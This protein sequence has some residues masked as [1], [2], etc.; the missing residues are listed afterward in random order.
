MDALASAQFEQVGSTAIYETRV[1]G[2]VGWAGYLLGAGAS[3]PPFINYDDSLKKYG[4]SYLFATQRPA[5]LDRDPGGFAKRVR[6]YIGAATGNRAVVWLA[7]A[8]PVVFGD[9]KRYGVGFIHLPPVYQVSGNLNLWFAGN[10]KFYVLDQSRIDIDGGALRLSGSATSSPPFIGFS[11]KGDNPLGIRIAPANSRIYAYVPFSGANTGCVTFDGLLDSKQAFVAQGLGQGFRYTVNNSAV[12]S[13]QA[14]QYAVMTVAALPPQLSIAGAFDLGDPANRVIDRTLLEQGY[15]RSGFAIK[16][17]PSLTS[18]FRTTGGRVVQLTPLGAGSADTAPSLGAGGFA[19]ATSVAKT[20]ATDAGTA[21]LSLAGQYALSA[22]GSSAGQVAKLMGGLFGSE[23]LSFRTF[24]A[25][26]PA[27][28]ND[29]LN[30][31]PSK[32]GYAPVFPFETADLNRPASGAVAPRLTDDY[33]TS[34]V[35]II[36]GGGAVDYLAEPEGSAIYGA[37]AAGAPDDAAILQSAPP[38][39]PLAQGNDK[40]FPLVPYGAVA[41][42]GLDGATLVQFE[43]QIVAATRKSLI[44]SYG[45]K[46]WSA[47]V[48]AARAHALHGVLADGPGTDGT[49]PQGFIIERDPGTGAYLNVSMAQ[50]LNQDGKTLPFA[51]SHPTPAMQDALQTNQ[52]FLVA[53]NPEPFGTGAQFA[54]TVN[55]AGWTMT[56]AVGAGASATAYR[57]VMIMKFCSGSLLDRVTNA[58]RWTSAE[59]FSLLPGTPPATAALSYT[60]LSQWLQDYIADAIT[61]SKGT[62]GPFYE[63]FARIAQDPNWTGV[64]VLAADL[65]Q[66]D[67]PPEIA[68]LAAGIDFTRFNAHHFGFTVSRVTVEASTGRITMPP[69]SSSLFGLIDY[70]DPRYAMNVSNGVAP[71]VPVPVQMSGDFDFTVLQLQSLFENARLTRFESH[72]QLSV[73]ALFG[74]PVSR[75]YSRGKPQPFTGIVLKGSYVDQGG[76]TAYVFEQNTT[77]VLTSPSNVLLAVAFDRVQFNT[78]GTQDQGATVASNFLVWGQLDFTALESNTGETLDLLSFGSPPDTPEAA[79]G[80]GLAFSGLAVGM[81]YPQATPGAKRFEVATGNLAWNLNGSTM[82]DT[83][84]FRGFALQLK[85]FVNASGDQKPSDLGFLPVTSQLNLTE[86]EG[87]WFGVV[88]DITLGGPGALASGV[89]F[90]SQL[91]VAWSP[92]T[93]GSDAEHAVFIGMSLPGAA[94]GASLFSIQGV[95]KVAVGAISILRQPVPTATGRMLADAAPKWFYCLRIDDIAIKIFGIAKLPPSANIQ[96]FLFGDPDNTGSLGWYAAYVAD[97][98]PGCEQSL[99]FAKRKPELQEPSS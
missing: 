18:E 53:V 80:V 42:S 92:V 91:L 6:D 96:F 52:L 57:N 63:N 47:R 81:T 86:L 60:G 3:L 20:V 59:Q 26:L 72:V 33:Q 29:R 46:T 35:T 13:L 58:N 4:G 2:S 12:S 74:A 62:S 93:T 98:N 69:G 84:L 22:D 94:P 39:M 14:A 82:R 8:N 61:R 31:I 49:T 88:Y 89:G 15:L 66:R 32:P 7:S 83:S 44:S 27:A 45:S 73:A 9:F 1:A 16:A 30:A 99:A 97:D 55:I 37:A 50:S 77:N 65:G 95:I 34:W 21:Y 36:S 85:S 24:D 10:A 25:N 71:D 67:M 11:G 5:D 41:S 19:F 23:A 90:Q 51:L 56:A 38:F 48:Q 76:R 40:T 68:G 70:E 79:L 54:N 78:L 87:P 17:A 75:L 43:S 28:Q 64:I